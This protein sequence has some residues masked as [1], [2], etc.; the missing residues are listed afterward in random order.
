[1]MRRRKKKKRREEREA[2]DCQYIDQDSNENSGSRL[3]FTLTKK[4]G[5]FFFPSDVQYKSKEY[6]VFHW[7]IQNNLDRHDRQYFDFISMIFD[8]DKL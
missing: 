6:S 7:F 4:D 8:Q 5:Q 1:M 3:R 2:Y